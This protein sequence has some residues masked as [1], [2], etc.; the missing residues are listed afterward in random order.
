MLTNRKCV[1]CLFLGVTGSMSGFLALVSR[2]YPFALAVLVLSPCA[3]AL[4]VWG[5]REIRRAA[6]TMGGKSAALA[7]ISFSVISIGFLALLPA[8]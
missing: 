3:I 6:R 8:T 1:L 5:R 7:G 4:G 2:I